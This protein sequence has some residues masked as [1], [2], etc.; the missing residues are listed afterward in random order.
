MKIAHFLVEGYKKYP[1]KSMISA[2]QSVINQRVEPKEA[3]ACFEVPERTLYHYL[4]KCG[5]SGSVRTEAV[6][7]RTSNAPAQSVAGPSGIPNNSVEIAN[8][9]LEDNSD[10]SWP[11]L[12]RNESSESDDD[13]III[14]DEENE[15]KIEPEE[16]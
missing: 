4:N 3:A 5:Y 15:V 9:V 16:L 2:I 8:V 14:E 13:V 10:F 12:V 6:K 11:D 1:A 7:N